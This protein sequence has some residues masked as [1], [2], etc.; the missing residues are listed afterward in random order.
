MKSGQAISHT[1]QRKKKAQMLWLQVL[2][3]DSDGISPEDIAKKYINEK[4]GK[5][6]TIKH[7]YWILRRGMK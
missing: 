7:I 3:D 5:P 4:T 2:K 1:A 6:Y